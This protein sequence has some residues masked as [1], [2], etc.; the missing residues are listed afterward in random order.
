[1]YGK[2]IFQEKEKKEN[3]QQKKSIHCRETCSLS[4]LK[5]WLIAYKEIQTH[6]TK[7]DVSEKQP[8]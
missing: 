5:G 3:K 7:H 6:V 8:L 4:I 2:D 1:M